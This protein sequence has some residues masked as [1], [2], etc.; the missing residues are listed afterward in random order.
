MYG[1]I[2]QDHAFKGLDFVHVEL[3]NQKGWQEVQFASFVSS[4]IEEGLDPAKMPEVRS[5]L[6]EMGL[7]TYDVLPPYLADSTLR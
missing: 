5:R 2:E 6:K 7:E 4:L 3:S 1:R